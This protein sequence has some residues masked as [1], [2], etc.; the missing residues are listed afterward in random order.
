MDRAVAPLIRIADITCRI[1]GDLLPDTPIH[2]V[3]IN[4]MIHFDVGSQSAREEIG[5]KLAPREPWG[6]WGRLSLPA[7]ARD[8]EGYCRLRSHS[9]NSPIDPL[10]GFRPNLSRPR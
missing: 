5:L 2:Q 3:G 7:T 4:R 8:M 10:V 9:A 6:D 1:F